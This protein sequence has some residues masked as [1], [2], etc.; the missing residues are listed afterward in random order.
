MIAV[1]IVWAAIALSYN[2]NLPMSFFVGA[3]SGCAYTVGRVWRFAQTRSGAG[4]AA[5][6]AAR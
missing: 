5:S 4:A 6:A 1:A 3:L 2:T